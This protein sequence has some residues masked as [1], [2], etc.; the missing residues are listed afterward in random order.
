M[1]SGIGPIKPENKRPIG[2]GPTPPT[3][4][5]IPEATY[6]S[7]LNRADK[8]YFMQ[9]QF[10]SYEKRSVFEAPFLMPL[11]GVTLPIP[12]KINDV[13]TVIW[14]AVEG[15]ALA[16]AYDN[17]RSPGNLNS[18]VAS[19]IT[20]AAGGAAGAAAGAAIGGRFGAVG[21]L[22]GIAAG[23]L[24]G[25]LGGGAAGGT[26]L[27]QGFAAG[28]GALGLQALGPTGELALGLLLGMA[29]NPFLTML[30]KQGDFK[31]HTLSWTFSPHNEQESI[32]LVNIIN[33]FKKNMLPS[34]VGGSGGLLLKY[35][36]LVLIGIYPDDFFTFKFK[37]CAI[38]SAATDYSGAG[39]PSFFENGAPTVINFSLQLKEIELWMQD[40][41][42]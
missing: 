33:S 19:V 21:R 26:A 37:P 22:V 25:G 36:N 32:N 41:Y 5:S 27:G 16:A 24:L 40:D 4:R 31:D 20:G 39:Q 11:G 30:F 6:P 29:P 2:R 28:A 13:Q 12:K 23:G 9:F 35:P 14:Q 15:R 34:F 7:D 38:I 10:I 17:F 42:N 18:T 3:T 8:N 1:P